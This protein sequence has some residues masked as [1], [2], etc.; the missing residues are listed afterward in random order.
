MIAAALRVLALAACFAAAAVQAATAPDEL[1]RAGERIYQEGLLPSGQ[2]LIGR[3]RGDV[4]RRGADAACAA[5]HR[6]SGHGMTEGGIAIRP[7]TAAALFDRTPVVGEPRLVHQFGH[8]L[9]PAYDQRGLARVLRQGIDVTGRRLDLLMP[10]YALNADEFAAL[11]AYLRTLAAEPAPGVGDADIRLATVIQP[12]IASERRQAMIEVLTAFVG[13]KNAGTRS[14]EKRRQVGIMRMQRAYR[15]WHLD[16]WQLEGPAES[17]PEQLETYYRRQPVFALV[18]GLGDADWAPIEAFSERRHLPC[19][20][21]QTRLPGRAG[22]H[23]YTLYLSRG[24]LL[25]AD[26]LAKHLAGQPDAAVLQVFRPGSAGAE[27]AKQLRAALPGSAARLEDLVLEQPADAGFWQQLAAR[28]GARSL[29]LWLAG[30]DLEGA[31]AALGDR[32]AVYLSPGLLGE[33]APAKRLAAAGTPPLLAYPWP[34]AAAR[35]AA[36]GRTRAWLRRNGIADA[37]DA[38]QV[39]T[40]FAVTL[41]GDVLAHIL[42]NF[43]R[44]YFIERLEH[45]VQQSLVAASYPHVSLGPD[46]RFAAKGSYVVRVEPDAGFRAVSG[47]IVP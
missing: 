44:E 15:H 27:A 11:A 1:L 31:A 16:V 22:R 19:V 34:D 35:E 46:Q 45:A 25:E 40:F 3:G 8:T 9:R 12:G 41:V 10:R 39:D 29:V 42:D 43:S 36:L 20:F 5:C 21:P 6:R 33:L 24:L 38:T 4:V 2:P 17:W 32:A 14:D 30:D 18:G 28:R 23:L 37:G 26:V 13:D 7:I 47:W